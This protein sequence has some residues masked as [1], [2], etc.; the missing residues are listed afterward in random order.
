LLAFSRKQVLQP[1]VVELRRVVSD[2]ATLLRRLLGA[3]VEF[4]LQLPPTPLWVNADENQLEQVVL[5]LVINARDAM[6]DGGTVT[7]ALDHVPAGAPAL[8]HHPGM[9]PV[10]YARLKVS[11]TGVGMDAATQAHI[12]EP[13]FTTKELGKG[14][15]L[16]LATVY[17]IVKQSDGWIWV[18]STP[19]VGTTFEILLPAVPAPE[20]ETAAA[21]QSYRDA[22]GSE[23]ILVVDDEEGVREVASQSLAVQGY[24]VL[25]AESGE[26]ALKVA[27]MENGPI[28]ALIT[29]AAMPGMNGPALA[30]RLRD[31]RPQ[32]RVLFMSGYAEDAA[33]RDDATRH[34]EAFLQKPFTLEALAQKLRALLSE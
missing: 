15:G 18:D 23:T 24:R 21:K 28:H 6:P 9:P 5:N 7:V 30:K 27:A 34:G 12:F 16:G 13:F 26:Q 3:V 2:I 25:T 1:R 22:R 19:G 11:D 31:L 8:H 32:T 4:R 20:Q 33:I 17:G 29:D 14:T 10:D